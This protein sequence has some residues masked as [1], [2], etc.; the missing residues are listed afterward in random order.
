PCVASLRKDTYA[1]E[2]R[3]VT[4]RV[5]AHRLNQNIR[6]DGSHP[7]CPSYMDDRMAVQSPS[8]T[9]PSPLVVTV[10]RRNRP[11]ARDSPKTIRSPLSIISRR[12]MPWR[13]EYSLA[14]RN[15]ASGNS[16]VVFT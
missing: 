16:M 1:R 3:H 11:L 2:S 5:L 14:W 15:S 9:S 7:P 10:L 8:E 4:L 6:V 12:G 13:A